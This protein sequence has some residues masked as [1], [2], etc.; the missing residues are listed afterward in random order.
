MPNK[1]IDNALKESLEIYEQLYV[2]L[3][4]KLNSNI[5]LSI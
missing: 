2:K 3:Q 4:N 1:N 5:K